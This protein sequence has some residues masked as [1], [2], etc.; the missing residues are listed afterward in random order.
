MYR[1][2]TDRFA[3]ILRVAPGGIAIP[4]LFQTC[5]R[6]IS[7]TSDRSIFSARGE[8]ILTKT[9]L[10]KQTFKEDMLGICGL[11]AHADGIVFGAKPLFDQVHRLLAIRT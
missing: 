4:V 2:L 8:L 1:R 6:I 5:R 11:I 7:E 9:I 3:S 10:N